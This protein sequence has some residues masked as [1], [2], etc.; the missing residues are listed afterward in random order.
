MTDTPNLARVY[1]CGVPSSTTLLGQRGAG[2]S[3]NVPPL[4]AVANAIAQATGVRF[5]E[6]P[7][8]PDKILLALKRR[9]GAL[10]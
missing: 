1:D 2:E 8:T 9:Q 7:I 6:L 4:A 10:P 5:S 3:G